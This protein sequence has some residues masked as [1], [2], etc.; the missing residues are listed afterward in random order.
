MRPVTLSYL[1]RSWASLVLEIYTGWGSYLSRLNITC[2]RLNVTQKSVSVAITSRWRSFAA[3]D[4][5]IYRRPSILT[6]RKGMGVVRRGRLFYRITDTGRYPFH[7]RLRHPSFSS[8]IQLF[9]IISDV[10]GNLDADSNGL[11]PAR[12]PRALSRKGNKWQPGLV[13]SRTR[14]RA[15][16]GQ[17]CRGRARRMLNVS[18]GGKM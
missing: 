7:A 16:V 2:C 9:K 17:H 11:G 12:S 4:S 8:D 15:A 3:W 18:H 5:V 10:H 14:G 1:S 13:P 6:H